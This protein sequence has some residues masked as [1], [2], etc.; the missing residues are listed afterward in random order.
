MFSV[1]KHEKKYSNKRKNLYKIEKL[2]YEVVLF[3]GTVPV[4]HEKKYSNK[5]K[6]LYKIEK[7]FYEVVLFQGTVPV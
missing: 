2:F 4:K 3:Q 1:R 6:N 7:L 5:R